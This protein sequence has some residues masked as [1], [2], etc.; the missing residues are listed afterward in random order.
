MASG[1]SAPSLGRGCVSG[2]A[3]TQRHHPSPG[4][5]GLGT[6]IPEEERGVLAGWQRWLCCRWVAAIPVASPEAHKEQAEVASCWWAS[7]GKRNTS[8]TACLSS[9]SAAKYPPHALGQLHN[10]EQRPKQK[11]SWPQWSGLRH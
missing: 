11:Y 1:T 7:A 3:V 4:A 8:L 9:A 2:F 10:R 5:L 6:S